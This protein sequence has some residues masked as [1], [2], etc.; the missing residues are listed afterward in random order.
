[1]VLQFRPS[2]AK[3]R[4]N[5]ETGLVLAKFRESSARLLCSTCARI[6]GR[7]SAC[8]ACTA[9]RAPATIQSISSNPTPF[10]KSADDWPLT[11]AAGYQEAAQ[12]SSTVRPR[13]HTTAAR[14]RTRVALPNK[15]HTDQDLSARQTCSRPQECFSRHPVHHHQR[16]RLSRRLRGR[17]GGGPRATPQHAMHITQCSPSPLPA[18]QD[19]TCATAR[20]SPY[21][22]TLR[23]RGMSHRPVRPRS[24]MLLHA[25][26]RS[27]TVRYAPVEQR[28]SYVATSC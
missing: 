10:F 6:P 26:P 1:M 13:A 9:Q 22:R 14:L 20:R 18:A 19:Y 3:P 23:R 5:R 4:L 11:V 15:Q 17:A 8:L 7:C 12:R 28:F 21:V 27:F 16:L 24:T 25:Y 2:R